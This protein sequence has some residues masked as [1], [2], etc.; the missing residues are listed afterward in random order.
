M[1]DVSISACV[2]CSKKF[3]NQHSTS[4][5][6]AFCRTCRVSPT[7]KVVVSLASH[8]SGMIQDSSSGDGEYVC[9]CASIK[10]FNI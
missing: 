4:P 2:A 3:A 6:H 10:S 9:V 8:A 5:D 1:S 7:K